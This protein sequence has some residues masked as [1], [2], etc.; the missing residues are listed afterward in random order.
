MLNESQVVDLT[1]KE[2]CYNCKF[3]YCE[4]ET[5]IDGSINFKIRSCRRNPPKPDANG[6][7]RFPSIGITDWCGSYS[8]REVANAR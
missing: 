1:K 3:F 2:C 4:K 6:S 7:G 8:R 5:L